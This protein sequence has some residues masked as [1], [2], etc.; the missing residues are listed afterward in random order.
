MRKILLVFGTRPEAIKLCPVLLTLRNSGRFQVRV[1]VTAQ[2][3]A[4]LDQV[5]AAFGVTPDYDLDLMQPGQTLA[6]ITARILAA[7]EPVIAAERPDMILVQGDTTTTLAGALAAF[8]QHSPVGHVEAGLRTGDLAQPFPEE[9]NRVV[10]TELA[11]LHFAPTEAARRNLLAAGVCAER[12]TITGNSGI[13]A[14][15]YVRDALAD[16]RL[17]AGDW[18]QL[19]PR[20]RLIVVTAHRRESFGD[21]FSRIC[22]ALARLAARPDIQ[23]I[24]PVHR[25]PNVMDPVYARLGGLENVFLVEPLDYVPFVDLMRRAYLLIT[26]SGGVQEEGPSLGKP[27]LVMR[28]K[29]ERP[30]AVAAGTVKLVGTDAE[31][32]V[33]EAERLLDDEAEYQRMARVLNPYG[34]GHASERICQSMAAYCERGLKA[35]F[36]GGVVAK[37]GAF[38]DVLP[39]GRERPV[40]GLL[41]DGQFAGAVHGGLGG[42]AGAQAMAGVGGRIEAGPAGRSLH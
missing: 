35:E 14:V 32:I 13:D 27:I 3:R 2:H 28:E 9:M 34:D 31:R 39:D 33:G 10:A 24:Y 1:C 22:D 29:T 8:Y 26:D 25:N 11:A 30:E 23:I 18:P 40:A 12:I 38:T 42:Q 5:L 15:F 20:R 19:D 4:M 36:G 37:Q 7:L 17:A 41:H 6:Q 16:G 21:G